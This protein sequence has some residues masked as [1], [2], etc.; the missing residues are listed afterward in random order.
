MKIRGNDMMTI[1]IR[2]IHM[3]LKDEV[4]TYFGTC[5]SITNKY[6]VDERASGVHN[7][8]PCIY[9]EFMYKN[10]NTLGYG[11]SFNNMQRSYRIVSYVSPCHD[12]I[13]IN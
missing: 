10:K 5:T 6:F 12:N 7:F 13:Q 2:T 4:V 8:S 1:V 3:S 11:I 9:D